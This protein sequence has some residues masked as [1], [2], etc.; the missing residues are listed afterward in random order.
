M[1]NKIIFIDSSVFMFRA[2]FAWRKNKSIK[3]TWQYLNMVFGILKLLNIHDKDLIIIA[4]DSSLG[5]WRKEVDYNYKSNRKEERNKFT[6]IDWTYMF[7]MFRALLKTLNRTTNFHIIEIDK[8]E[9]DDIIAHGCKYFKDNECIIVSSDS[10]FEMLSVYKNVKL[11][12]PISK[13]YK[14]VKNPYLI[15]SKKIE[16]E[17]TDNLITAIKTEEDYNNRELIVNLI[18]LPDFVTSEVEKI[19]SKLNYTK[20]FDANSIP[21]NMCKR[22]RSIFNNDKV[23]VKKQVKYENQ[24]SLIN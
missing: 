4:V 10:D 15:L 9:A 6:D 24:E 1:N 17:K 23:G 18:N 7:E 19:L 3:P 22:F 12:S 5:S 16:E 11:F 20:I 14:E 8:L 21:F 2:I 13:K